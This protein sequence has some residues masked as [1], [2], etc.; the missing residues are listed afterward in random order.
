MSVSTLDAT[1]ACL[2]GICIPPTLVIWVISF[3]KVRQ[4][5]DRLRRPFHWMKAAYPLLA[6]WVFLSLV[7]PHKLK[8]I[9][10]SIAR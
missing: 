2:Y 10:L 1:Q 3:F 7:L 6:V 4:R 9:N 8:I 5:G